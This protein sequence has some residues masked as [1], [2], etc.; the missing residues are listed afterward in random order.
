MIPKKI[1][2][3]YV[4]ENDADKTWSEDPISASDCKMKNREYTDLS[5]V[6]HDA[7]EE[8]RRD[9]LLLGVDND[10]V[11][12]YKWC[13]QEVCWK[14]V[15]NYCAL[16]KWAYIDDLLPKTRSKMIRMCLINDTK[17]NH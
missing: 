16:K 11:S 13:L 2:L 15:V 4:D 3:N 14:D 7:S 12:L 5:Q 1:Y 10:G 8:P 9:E 6:W 17:V